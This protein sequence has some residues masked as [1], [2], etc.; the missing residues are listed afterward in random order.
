MVVGD[1]KNCHDHRL[2]RGEKGGLLLDVF[3]VGVQ[4]MAMFW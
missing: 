1:A 3:S 2:G 4:I